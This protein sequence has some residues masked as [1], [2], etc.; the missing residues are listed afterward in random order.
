MTTARPRPTHRRGAAII[1]VAG[2]AAILSAMAF[3]FLMQM[4]ADAD[5]SSH[6][7][8]M[9]QARTMLAAGLGYIQ[10]SSRMGWADRSSNGI[11]NAEGYGW[12]DVR[13]GSPGPR[14]VLHGLL[15]PGDATTGEGPLYPAIGGRA[16]RCP[17]YRERR[18]PRAVMPILYPNPIPADATG[19]AVLT[20][21]AGG[22]SPDWARDIGYPNAEPTPFRD[23]QST[24]AAAFSRWRA[25]DR[26]PVQSSSA[27][28]WFR[29]YRMTKADALTHRT[30]DGRL[31]PLP[32]SPALF[33]VT[34]SAGGTLGYRDW[35]E[36]I[37]CEATDSFGNDPR[38]F[39]TLRAEET[40]FWYACEWSPAVG[41]D[42]IH[43]YASDNDLTRS[44]QG[45]PNWADSN[46]VM[47]KN[48]GGTIAWIERLVHQPPI[49]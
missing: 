33:L 28:P 44:G 10:E 48:Q 21:D 3:A 30:N 4:R 49:W 12:I 19:G 38:L 27:P 45:R 39:A 16:A 29:V 31:R 41:Y 13:D 15:Y 5:E 23:D 35:D 32:W 37:T 47:S 11:T 8:R 1:I 26:T 22:P 6:F 14:D 7:V 24:G 25:G 36:V 18:P 20:P 46:Q 40:I 34:C 2:I 9:T 17:M 42:T 43:H